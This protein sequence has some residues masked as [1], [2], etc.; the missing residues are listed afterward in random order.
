MV[1]IRGHLQTDL[2]FRGEGVIHL[3]LMFKNVCTNQLFGENFDVK[4]G[5]GGGGFCLTSNDVKRK[6][7]SVW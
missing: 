3:T 7:K 1:P 2:T 6:K 4:K 5:R